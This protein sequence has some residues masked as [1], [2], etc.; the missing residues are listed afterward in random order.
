[1]NNL[2]CRIQQSGEI[3]RYTTRTNKDVA[4]TAFKSEVFV[5]GFASEVVTSRK[6]VRFVGSEAQTDALQLTTAR[7]VG[8]EKRM[9]LEMYSASCGTPIFR[10]GLFRTMWIT[11]LETMQ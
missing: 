7:T 5:L 8:I 10:I 3:K 4:E 11:M 9:V 1:M 2:A 6:F